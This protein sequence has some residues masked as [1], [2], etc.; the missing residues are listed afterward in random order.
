MSTAI[1]K[2]ILAAAAVALTTVAFAQAGSPADA[3]KARQQ[4]FKDMGAAF[5]TIRDQLRGTADVAAVKAAAA[6]I[7]KNAL[8]EH[9]W[10]PKGTGPEAGVKTA[11]KP[12]IWT[13][14]EGFA[15]AVKKFEEEADKFAQLA[16][17][18]DMSA[19]GAGVKALGQSCGGCHD[20]YR[21]KED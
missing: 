17:A 11:A 3:I 6:E 20:K 10:F 16:D 7:K 8:D 15:A 2:T 5:K 18:G 19:L 14:G 21:Q 9:N 12:V 4:H 1:R 13:D